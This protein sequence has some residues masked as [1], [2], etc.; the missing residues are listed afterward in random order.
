MYLLPC[1]HCKLLFHKSILLIT[2][3]AEPFKDVAT[4][5]T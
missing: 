4:E 5:I 3:E 1:A 2:V